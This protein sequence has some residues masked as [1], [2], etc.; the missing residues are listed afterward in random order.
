[1]QRGRHGLYSHEG[2]RRRYAHERARLTGVH[3]AVHATDSNSN[4]TGAPKEIREENPVKMEI[5]YLK[6]LKG[7]E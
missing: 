1:M 5:K 6:Q 3:E 4:S 2:P 7:L